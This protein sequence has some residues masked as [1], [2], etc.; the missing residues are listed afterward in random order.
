MNVIA[1]PFIGISA[2]AIVVLALSRRTR[3][4]RAV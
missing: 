3:S 2:L 4:A 1:M